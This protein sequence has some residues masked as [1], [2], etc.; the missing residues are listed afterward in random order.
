MVTTMLLTTDAFELLHLPVDELV[1]L[2]TLQAIADNKG[3]L[4]EASRD[5][6][7]SLRTLQRWIKEAAAEATETNAA[8]SAICETH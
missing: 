7:I 2:R 8:L 1:E 5:L 3:N 6:G 4:K